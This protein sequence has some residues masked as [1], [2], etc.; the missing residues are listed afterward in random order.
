MLREVVIGE[1]KLATGAMPLIVAEL[2][3]NHN[4]DV[5]TAEEMIL[6]AKLAG[7]DAVKFQKRTVDKLYTEEELARPKA[8]PFGTTYGDYKWGVEFTVAEYDAMD[9]ICMEEGIMWFASCWDVEAINFMVQYDIPCIKVASPSLTDLELVRYASRH[10]KPLIISTG[11]STMRQIEA[12]LATIEEQHDTDWVQDNVILLQC[13]NIYPVEDPGD[14]DLAVIATMRE[15]LDLLTGFSGHQ[16]AWPASVMAMA[17]GAVYIEMHFTL[18]RGMWGSDQK[19]SLT[20]EEFGDMVD[21]IHYM[22][23]AIGN[24]VKKVHEPPEAFRRLRRVG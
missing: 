21:W 1:R 18:D 7:A 14:I 20:P 5:D 24:G 11:M 19:S 2:G 13:T 3:I 16:L 12:C 10:G 9:A 4:G 8:S 15:E 22:H 6:A 17:M 23:A